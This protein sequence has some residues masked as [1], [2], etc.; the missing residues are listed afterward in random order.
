MF[1]YINFKMKNKVI[2]A[3]F[4]FISATCFTQE[5][6][7]K[8]TVNSSRINTTVDKKIFTTLQNQLNNFFNNRKWTGDAFKQT[9]KIECNIILNLESVAD[10]NSYKAQLLVQAGRP[11]FGTTYNAAL[12]NY[13]DADVS[14][15]YTEYQPIEFNETRIGGSEPFA[16]N[17]TAILAY[18]ANIIL[19]FHYD[20]FSPKGGEKYFLKAQNIVNNAPEANGLNGWKA[21]DGL[22]NRYWL[23]ENITNTKGNILHSV[24]YEY[25]RNGFDKMIS[26]EKE[27][28]KSFLQ[29]FTLLKSYSQDNLNSMFV[30]FFLQNKLQEITDIFNRGSADD[31][32]KAVE[33][34]S[35]LDPANSSKYAEAI[36]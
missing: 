15:K 30:Q 34:L 14:F 20:S 13:Q 7:A 4:L 25:Y 33:I 26:N 3:I 9:E 8:I 24:L 23:I 27:A 5:F 31:K 12:L 21:F 19:G 32:T 16:A 10:Q 11:V 22:R 18:Y 6:Q 28:V 1:A 29:A 35:S 2:T 36:K 17:L